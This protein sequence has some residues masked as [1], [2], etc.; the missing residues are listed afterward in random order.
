MP[1]SKQDSPLSGNVLITT[2]LHLTALVEAE[3]Y[4][5]GIF[6]QI[7]EWAGEYS[8]DRVLVL[9]DL[10]DKKDYHPAELVN[11]I[12]REVQYLTSHVGLEMVFLKGNHDFLKD[13]PPFFSFL[14]HLDGVRY[15]EKPEVWGDSLFLPY[16]KDPEAD[17]A[18]I[19]FSEY[20]QIFMHQTVSGARASN[21]MPMAGI[22]STMFG[23]PVYSGDIH[24]PQKIGDVLYVGSPYHVHFGDRFRPRCLLFLDGEGPTDLQY[25]SPARTSISISETAE[26]EDA[27]L[28]A[29]DQV[30]VTVRGIEADSWPEMKQEIMDLCK[31]RKFKLSGLTLIPGI[32]RHRPQRESE[33]LDHQLAVDVLDA[34]DRWCRGQ[35]V[36]KGVVDLGQRI[37]SEC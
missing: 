6:E 19:L 28:R 18:A 11:G 37:I 30:K 24:V 14:R 7:A 21:G 29:G 5:W 4:R 10:T 33:K 36:D 34:F 32:R 13:G 12:V 23:T 25:D 22:S 9:G 16:T 20:K 35:G 15:V 17:W 2:D 26:L 8:L 3:A 27:G 31:K 1:R